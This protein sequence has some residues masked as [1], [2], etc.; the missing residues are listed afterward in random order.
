MLRIF[1]QQS[2][3]FL[4][5]PYIIFSLNFV[6]MEHVLHSSIKTHMFVKGQKI[7]MGFLT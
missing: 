6:D 5:T 7:S 1:L 3:T 2:F 4:I